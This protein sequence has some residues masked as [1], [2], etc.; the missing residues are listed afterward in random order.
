MRGRESGTTS[1]T[2]C[3][4][5]TFPKRMKSSLSNKCLLTKTVNLRAELSALLCWYFL[6]C[7][8]F[9]APACLF[10]VHDFFFF[11]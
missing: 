2:F 1:L 3:H 11:L 8:T 9:T 7:H 6:M 4:E 5:S 10:L